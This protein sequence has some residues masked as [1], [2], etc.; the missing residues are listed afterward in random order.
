ME[1]LSLE[2][3]WILVAPEVMSHKRASS[4]AHLVPR[5]PAAFPQVL[6]NLTAMT[7]VAPQDPTA[8]QDLVVP[9]CA[10]TL[11]DPSHYF[12][13]TQ[14]SCHHLHQDRVVLDLVSD[15]AALMEPSHYF[16][17]TQLSCYHLHQDRAASDLVPDGPAVVAKAVMLIDLTVAALQDNVAVLVAVAGRCLN[18]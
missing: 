10:C 16:R 14:L 13:P 11:T 6:A 9:H 8:T 1:T 7:A 18:M 17:P 2:Q 5:V 4:Y 15:S 3:C 12:R